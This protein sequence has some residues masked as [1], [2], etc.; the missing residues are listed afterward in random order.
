ME[1]TSLTQLQD[2]MISRLARIVGKRQNAIIIRARRLARE[3]YTTRAQAMGFDLDMIEA[4]I[5]QCYEMARLHH[6]E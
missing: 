2:A 4:Q 1:Y 5:G 3:F 6:G